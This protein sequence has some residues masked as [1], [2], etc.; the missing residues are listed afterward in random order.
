MPVAEESGWQK[1]Q[2]FGDSGSRARF[3]LP[4]SDDRE[5]ALADGC[6]QQAF[7]QQQP[8]ECSTAAAVGLG[9]IAEQVQSH[10]GQ[11]PINVASTV[12]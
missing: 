4:R 6:W 11:Q 3:W 5:I 12:A 1:G 9:T 10:R 7:W 8:A 2:P